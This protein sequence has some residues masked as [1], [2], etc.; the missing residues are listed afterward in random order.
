VEKNNA[1]I[2][3]VLWI[4][5]PPCVP[6]LDRLSCPRLR[7]ELTVA[8]YNTD[9]LD[10]DSQSEKPGQTLHYYESGQRVELEFMEHHVGFQENTA[11]PGGISDS[12]WSHLHGGH[13]VIGGWFFVSSED[14]I[15]TRQRLEAAD[16]I[17]PVFWS[18]FHKA[19]LIILPTVRIEGVET[20]AGEVLDEIRTNDAP[21]FDAERNGDILMLR[22]KSNSAEDAV[23][24][25][26]LAME[27]PVEFRPRSATPGVVSCLSLQHRR[28]RRRHD[29]PQEH[30]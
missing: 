28:D 29:S 10:V 30:P 1:L 18:E 8:H 16:L 21:E 4:A 11:R 22:P 6:R 3:D 23:R 9:A 13:A 15:D 5:L 12:L 2:P 19:H 20:G 17:V 26:A 7:K 14:V 25:A 24:I 27:L